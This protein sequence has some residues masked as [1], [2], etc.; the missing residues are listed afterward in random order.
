MNWIYLAT[1]LSLVLVTW[2]DN[3][4]GG[5]IWVN[6]VKVCESSNFQFTCPVYAEG[7]APWTG[8]IQLVPDTGYRVIDLYGYA[9][10]RG[11]TSRI[12]PDEWTS[13]LPEG[14]VGKDRY[15]DLFAIFRP[16]V[17]AI[18]TDGFETGD[19]TAWQ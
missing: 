16:V 18:F 5:Q 14:Q 12:S 6:G 1:A 15:L 2:I 11:D 8:T 4:V 10:V 19:T 13:I 3:R 17:D 9:Y 7:L